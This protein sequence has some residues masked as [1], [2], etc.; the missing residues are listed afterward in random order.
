MRLLLACALALSTA[1]QSSDVS[2]EVGARCDRAADCD[3]MCL[4]PSEDWPGGFCTVDCDTDA[5]CPADA[6]CIDDGEAGVC[7]FT[8]ATDPGCQFLGNG[9]TCNERNAHEADAP[10]VLVCRG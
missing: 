8:C 5:D 4:G 3:D 10:P 9:Y 7:A 1:C 6:A 2:R